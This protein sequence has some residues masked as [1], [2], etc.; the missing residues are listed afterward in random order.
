MAEF[1]GDVVGM[2]FGTTDG[3]KGWINRLAVRP[4]L[5][6]KD[7]AKM[8][9]ETMEA[10]FET[11]GLEVF[12]CLIED[13]SDSSKRLFEEIGYK[14]DPAVHYFSKRLKDGS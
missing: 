5:R 14:D 12:A 2:L 11:L 8:M 4:D 1:Q 7:V 6:R 13:H 3:R 10:R 9:I